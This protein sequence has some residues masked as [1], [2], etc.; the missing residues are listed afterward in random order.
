MACSAWDERL[1]GHERASSLPPTSTLASS[2]SNNLTFHGP[3]SIKWRAHG[4]E[5]KII[6]S[7]ALHIMEFSTVE[8][9]LEEGG[10][11]S[12]R[13]LHAYGQ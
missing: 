5:A 6:S 13:E 1:E 10:S 3:P 9:I 12:R 8:A 11:R 4:S 7:V 2:I